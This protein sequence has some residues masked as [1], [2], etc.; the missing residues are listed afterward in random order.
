MHE[1]DFRTDVLVLLVALLVF[2]PLFQRLRVGSVLGYLAAG[3]IVGPQVLGLVAHL[4]TAKHLGEVGVAFL[5]FAVGLE[6]KFGRLRLFGV[7]T[8]A[9]AL[10]QV[11]VTSAAFTAIGVAAGLHVTVAFLI[12]GALS[13]SSTAVVIQLLGGGTSM[14]GPIGRRALAILLVQDIM[15]GP[16]LVFVSV[17]AGGHTGLAWALGEAA[18]K[19]AGVILLIYLF[20]RTALRPLFRLAAGAGAPEVFMGATLLLVL[21]V[22]WA[23]EAAGLSMALGA[24][25]AGMMVADTD[26]RHQIAADI[27]PF[28]GLF[29]GLFFIT[30]GMTLDLHVAAAQPGTVLLLTAGLI[31]VKALLIAILAMVFGS[32]R[33][34]ALALGG[35]LSQ[36]SEFAFV[37]FALAAA[38]ALLPD[39]LMQLLTVAV[40]LSMAL[41]AAGVAVVRP[42]AR[43]RF[44]TGPS[45]L[46]KLDQEG[47]SF[48]GHVVIS[49]FGQVGMALARHLTTLEMRT[50]VLDLNPRRV[51]AGR[52]RRL[53]VF[54]GNAD[55][56]DVLE[57]AHV[58]RAGALVVAVP[59][60]ETAERITAV[61]HNAFPKL[62]I[63]VR[64]PD[65]SWV[66]RLRAAGAEAVVPESLTTA[67]DL[68]ERVALHFAMFGADAGEE[69]E[70]EE[71][72]E[73]PAAEPA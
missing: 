73:T 35:L 58:E 63:I 25:L 2:V 36:G 11:A 21:G 72:A 62:H 4:D 33:L 66:D 55:R 41:S 13:F 5:L 51:S 30:V 53:R 23:T 29:L 15:V 47:E 6:L 44:D 57:S 8:F 59:D 52:A 7:Q 32:T 31:A 67:M 24:F 28:R 68:A 9:L 14:T 37:I 38:Q 69:A 65:K 46:G 27:Q 17:A 56:R 1:A 19:S 61:A 64:A 60:G 16:M 48:S 45:R 12:G 49:G 26:F 10:A 18:L 22:G 50:V 34:R 43:R 42:W 71:E 3:V 20:E 39:D 40:G 54:Y 70:E